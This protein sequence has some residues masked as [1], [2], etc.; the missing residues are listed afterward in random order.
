MSGGGT[1]RSRS[2]TD[3]FSTH[4]SAVADIAPFTNAPARRP[5]SGST[6]AQSSAGESQSQLQ[7][8]T[9][10]M[11]RSSAPPSPGGSTGA[12]SFVTHSSGLRE[13]AFAAKPVA[14][15]PA[16]PSADS[17]TSEPPLTPAVLPPPPAGAGDG[18]PVARRHSQSSGVALE[19]QAPS[20]GAA[21]TSASTISGA[22]PLPTIP[23]HPSAAPLASLQSLSIPTATLSCS[24]GSG[25]P[26]SGQVPP[27][28]PSQ[29][30]PLAEH[31]GVVELAAEQPAAAEQRSSDEMRVRPRP[32]D[33]M[34]VRPR[35]SWI[36]DTATE[37]PAR[38]QS[39]DIVVETWPRT[40]DAAPTAVA[41]AHAAEPTPLTAPIAH[42]P[43]PAPPTPPTAPA[44]AAAPFVPTVPV[45]GAV[46]VPEPAVGAEG[47]PAAEQLQH[48]P[49][50][51]IADA[52]TSL[53]AQEILAAVRA[54]AAAAE[55]AAA[56]ANAA[57]VA[58]A[59]GLQPAA[60]SPGRRYLSPGTPHAAVTDGHAQLWQQ[61]FTPDRHRAEV[62]PPPYDHDPAVH[63]LEC[64]LIRSEEERADV[65]H[66]LR[67]AEQAIREVEGRFTSEREVMMRELREAAADRQ[68]L[69]DGASRAE[70]ECQQL[71]LQLRE[72]QRR[73]ELAE[74][75][76]GGRTSHSHRSRARPPPPRISPQPPGL[77]PQQ[78]F[79]AGP[80]RSVHSPGRSTVRPADAAWAGRQSRS[81][82]A[83]S[84]TTASTTEPWADRMLRR[85][86]RGPRP[87]SYA[88]VD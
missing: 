63:D 41:P 14:V 46:P 34:R 72:A 30:T 82:T 47:A 68:A 31:A 45:N 66:R 9:G 13:P 37:G 38:L 6:P 57:A 55:A 71:R 74:R 32:S 18:P 24:T 26:P 54:A 56:A 1:L 44:Y 52:A 62:A 16:D 22:R 64:R 10:P 78:V 21:Q 58:R 50:P 69:T 49:L 25:P 8:G 3:S 51:L 86:E 59:E 80:P 7:T 4:A 79:A 61:P 11:R 42:A 70:L 77:L 83:S 76:H 84:V 5:R 40:P 75:R 23:Q 53:P 33:E 85:I 17:S 35:P 28:A 19:V 67:R 36:V 88:L 60:A 2:P 20:G 48:A 39:Q 81:T 15:D 73:A 43:E 12:T 87:H 27:S 29:P 65:Q